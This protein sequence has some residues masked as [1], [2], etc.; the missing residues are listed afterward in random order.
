MTKRVTF[1]VNQVIDPTF[2]IRRRPVQDADV[3]GRDHVTDDR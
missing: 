1:D 2:A 3:A